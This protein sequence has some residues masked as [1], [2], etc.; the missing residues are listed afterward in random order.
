[1]N[2]SIPPSETTQLVLLGTGTPIADPKRFGPCIAVVVNH[3]PYLVDFGPGVVRR[4]AAAAAAGVQGL[5]PP[6]LTRTFV[7]HLHSDHTSGYPDLIFTP[8]VVGRKQAL[9]VYGPSGLRH[10]TDHI[11]EAYREDLRE[12][13]EGLEPGQPRCLRY[14]GS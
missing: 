3:Q 10:M 5:Q 6:N 1:M 4:A 8:G 12:R 9:Q 2:T 7:T 13:I 14:P 11:L